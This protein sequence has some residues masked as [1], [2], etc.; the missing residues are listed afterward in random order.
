MPNARSGARPSRSLHRLVAATLACA[1]HLGLIASPA[2]AIVIRHDRTDD[3]GTGR[4]PSANL[5]PAPFLPGIVST[6]EAIEHG[7]TATPDG[8]ELWFTRAI[9]TWGEPVKSQ[10]IYLARRRGDGSLGRPEPAPFSGEHFDDDPFPSPDGKWIYF[11]SDRPAQSKEAEGPDLWR[12]RRLDSGW[13]EP[14]HLAD[15]SSS[16]YDSSPVVTADGDLWFSSMRD[17]GLGSGDLWRAGSD[18]KGGFAAPENVGAPVNSAHGEWN[19]LVAPDESWL[20]FEASGRPTNITGSGDLYLS[21]N[22]PSGWSEPIHLACLNSPGSDLLPRFGFEGQ[23]LFASTRA[24]DGPQT[25]IYEI[26]LMDLLES[27]AA[28]RQ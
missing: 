17:G 12:V 28:P 27:C 2:A 6:R 16:G 21:M 7:A 5:R 26:R 11:V 19:L 4:G 9:G 14:E 8:R 20:I 24:P 25:D 23:L 3:A 1:I 13:G 10:T 15:V 18:G 22:G